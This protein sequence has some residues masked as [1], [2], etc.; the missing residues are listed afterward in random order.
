MAEGARTV[1]IAA[2]AAEAAEDYL[3]RVGRS[4]KI[5]RIYNI[6]QIVDLILTETM[7]K[8]KSVV[9]DCSVASDAN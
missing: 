7:V 6:A 4:L 5:V 9:T 8:S 1:F 3:A 2:P